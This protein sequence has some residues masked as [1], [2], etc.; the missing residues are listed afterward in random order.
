[1]TT[2][3]MTIRE[4]AGEFIVVSTKFED[5]QFVESEDHE[6]AHTTL[7]AARDDMQLTA[8][9]MDEF[10]FEIARDEN[11]I[12]VQFDDTAANAAVTELQND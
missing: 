4:E 8:D 12:T 2:E 3:Q 1:M 7:A 6:N 10:W 11:S 9:C 5:G